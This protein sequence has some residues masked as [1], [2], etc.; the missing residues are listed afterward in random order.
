MK[1]QLYLPEKYPVVTGEN[2]SVG[3]ATCW[4][5]PNLLLKKDPTIT[6]HI[7]L[8][9]TLYSKEGVSVILRNLCLN[10][11]IKTMVVW[12]NAPLSNTQFGIAGRNLLKTFFDSSIGKDNLVNGTS[13]RLHP[14]IDPDVLEKVRQNVKLLDLSDLDY[15]K[16][17]S[18]VKNLT[19]DTKPYMKPTS[20]PETKRDVDASA[21]SEEIGFAVHHPTLAGAWA[22]VVDRILLYGGIKKTEYGN[23]QKELQVVTWVIHQEDLAKFAI[24]DWPEELLKAVGMHKDMLKEYATAFLD[25]KLPEGTVYTYGSRL[26]NYPGDLDQV[27]EIVRHLKSSPITRRAFG[28]TL[29]PPFDMKHHSPPCLCLIQFLTTVEGKLNLIATFRSHDIFKAAL[30]NA[31]ALLN[32]QKYVAEET[33]LPIGSLAIT[34]HSAHMYEEDWENAKKLVDCALRGRV[35]AQFDESADLDPRGIVRIQVDGG[36]IILKLISLSGTEIAEEIG[37][38]AREIA[39]RLAKRNLLSRGDHYVDITLELIK[40]ELALQLNIPYNQDKPLI[41]DKHFTL[42]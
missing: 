27:D 38:K 18:K 8:M 24:P 41:V 22:Q 37:T 1:Y 36:K 39:L 17:I 35:K 40:A 7:G 25:A 15:D 26:R 13:D 21:P 33:N 11:T 28:T 10:P 20:F 14:E 4:S 23:L 34:S 32:L 2:A 42:R 31:F 29:Y 12:G 3:L 9:G 30:P 16:M 5:D 6:K 19:S